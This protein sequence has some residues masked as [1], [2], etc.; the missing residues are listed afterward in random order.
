MASI[1]YQKSTFKAILLSL[2]QTLFSTLLNATGKA[3]RLPDCTLSI[4]QLYLKKLLA[5]N[6]ADLA[7]VPCISI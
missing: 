5:T 6:E 1:F 3:A 4:L 7:S 2:F